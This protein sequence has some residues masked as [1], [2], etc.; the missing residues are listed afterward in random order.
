[1]GIVGGNGMTT[2]ELLVQW[3]KFLL[4][5]AKELDIKEACGGID[6]DQED[7]FSTTQVFLRAIRKLKDNKDT[8]I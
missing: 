3:Y 7:Q 8:A 2:E 5:I 6:V 1:M 4:R